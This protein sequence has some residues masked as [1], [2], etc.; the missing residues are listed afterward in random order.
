M[1][2]NVKLSKKKKSLSDYRC[3]TYREYEK[4]LFKKRVAPINN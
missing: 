2:Y 3:F 1:I 4:C